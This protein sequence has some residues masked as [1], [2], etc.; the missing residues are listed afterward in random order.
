M[1]GQFGQCPP[2]LLS[3]K[4]SVGWQQDPAVLQHW[5]H[6]RSGIVW[7][8]RPLNLVLTACSEFSDFLWALEKE[9]HD[10]PTTMNGDMRVGFQFNSCFERADDALESCAKCAAHP[11]R[12]EQLHDPPPPPSISD[13]LLGGNG[14]SG[15]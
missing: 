6:T 13:G 5:G 9:R 8:S 4:K 15:L 11:V 2:D 1:A 10:T 12:L 7:N 14:C 3:M